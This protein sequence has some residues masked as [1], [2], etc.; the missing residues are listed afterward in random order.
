MRKLIIILTGLF[1][2]NASA[3]DRT[4]TG[5]VTNDK[6]APLEGVTVTSQDG[7]HGT[8]TDINGKYSLTISSSVKTLLFSHVS[9]ETQI[10]VIGK[11]LAVNVIW[12]CTYM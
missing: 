3:Q 1:V 9:F 5:N 8:Q 6:G 10:R 12:N 4:I 2:L 7:K 11:L